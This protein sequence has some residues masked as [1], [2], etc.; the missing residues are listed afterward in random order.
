MI[1]VITGTHHQ[2]F[3]RLVR[4]MDELAP[5][6]KEKVIIQKGHTK[7]TPKN[8]EYFDF[9]TL[10]EMYGYIRK[11]RVVVT[12]GGIGSITDALG[13]GKPVVVV[14]RLRR[15]GEHVDDHQLDITRELEKEGMITAVYDIKDLKGAIKKAKKPLKIKGGRV[16]EIIK[17][18]LRRVEENEK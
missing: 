9:C 3:E 8:S 11:A 13:E 17:D 1:F 15:F 2:G 7:Y 14:P 4:G 16:V 12:H 10:E 6:L 18:F 5:H